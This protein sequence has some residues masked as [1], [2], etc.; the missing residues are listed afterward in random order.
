[1]N[2]PSEIAEIVL[3]ILR[4][5]LLR[6]RAVGW[7]GDGRRCAV[8]A[9]HLHNL[10]TLLARFSADLLRFYWEVER[11]AFLSQSESD[12]CQAFEP[13]WTHLRRSSAARQS[14]RVFA[15]ERR[16]VSFATRTVRAADMIAA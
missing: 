13:L 1:M 12:A 16:G 8:E 4:V 5:G 11:P 2:C 15:E 10:P 14:R 3:E 9:D 6:V 7:C